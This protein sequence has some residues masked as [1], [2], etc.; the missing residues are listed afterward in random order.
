MSSAKC[1][2]A[3]FDKELQPKLEVQLR[4]IQEKA[5]R[6]SYQCQTGSNCRKNRLFGLI[7][8]N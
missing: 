8:V 7:E 6:K 5:K 1:E 3:R 4:K 2:G